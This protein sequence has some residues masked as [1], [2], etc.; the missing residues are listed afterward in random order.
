[1]AL[2]LYDSRTKEKKVF[3]PITE[4]RV[5]MYVCGLTPQN[6]AHLGHAVSAIRLGAVRRYLEFRGYDVTYVEN[7]TD[8]DDKIIARSIELGIP[9]AEIATKYATEY[10]EQLRRAGVT[11]PTFV[12]RVSEYIEKIIHYTQELVA[13][14]SAYTTETGDVYFDVSALKSYG[15][16]SGRKLDDAK[17][18]HRIQNA[19]EKHS[20]QD[21][22]LW[23]SDTE[24]GWPSPWGIGRPGWHIECSAMCNDLL[25]PHIDIHGGGLDLLFPH[26]ENEN[27]QCVAHSGHK[28]VNYWMHSGLLNID[29]VKMSKSLGN[30]ITLRDAIDSYGPNLIN[31]VI[32][33]HQ[34]RSVID[35]NDTLFLNNI[36]MLLVWVRAIDS[37]DGWQTITD[38]QI[39]ENATAQNIIARFID[40]MDDDIHTPR[41]LVILSPYLEGISSFDPEEARIVVAVV[42]KLF[43]VLGMFTDYDAE[44]II[45][46]LLHFHQKDFP[47]TEQ[48]TLSAIQRVIAM[49]VDARSAKNYD[50]SDRLRDMLAQK[51]IKC[52]DNRDSLSWEFII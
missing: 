18:G 34:Y 16:L 50:E 38:Q 28:F 20:E 1:M 47:E 10:R 35:F 4:G 24:H 41:G 22:A 33:R 19:D 8:I 37:V 2:K 43:R 36:N 6:S 42:V 23:K 9:P 40:A 12:P 45:N 48:L 26:H 52:I 44:A 29:G 17:S 25:G 13:K 21:F 46:E 51:K 30:F 27:A 11:D 15:E 39:T 31:M 7:I 14:G 32:V 3:K 49:R 5:S